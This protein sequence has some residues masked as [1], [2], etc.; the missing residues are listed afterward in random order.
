LGDI[1]TG[2]HQDPAPLASPET[3]SRLRLPDRQWID[4]F[5]DLAFAAGI[6]ELSGAFAY[7]H[8]ALGALWFGI[9]YAL[10]W[11][12]WLVTSVV[13]GSLTSAGPSASPLSLALL[14]AQMGTVLFLAISAGDSLAESEL[15][16]DLLLSLALVISL[17]L[18]LRARGTGVARV[19]RIAPLLAGAV[20]GL[21]ASWRVDGNIS[22]VIWAGSLILIAVA[23]WAVAGGEGLDLHR[24][25]HRLAELTV[26]VIGEV[27]VKLALTVSEESVWSVSVTS[28]L[29]TFL[30]LVGLWWLYFG[31]LLADQTDLTRPQRR[32][33]ILAHLPLHVGLLALAV[34]LAK[35]SVGSESLTE[36]GGL[37]SLVVAPLTLCL[38]SVGLIAWAGR[39]DCRGVVG[40]ATVVMVLLTAATAWLHLS[41]LTVGYLGAAVTMAT[42]LIAARPPRGA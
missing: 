21:A 2:V 35:L 42:A 41:P 13:T 32:R 25:K 14:V 31:D 20:L 24:V 6:I 30:I 33:W 3:P 9:T 11:G 16:F 29:P 40:W 15:V 4:L 34:G 22:L 17:V 26:V 19:R 18:T 28:L 39:A 36:R 1:V 7:D 8:G 12:M 27:M 10:M 37:L 38:G 23:A 5:Y